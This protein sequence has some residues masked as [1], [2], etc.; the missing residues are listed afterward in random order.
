MILTR[1]VTVTDAAWLRLKATVPCRRIRVKEN[2]EAAGWPTARW[3]AGGGILQNATDPVNPAEPTGTGYISLTAG[4][5]KVF[6]SPLHP[7]AYRPNEHVA[8][9]RLATGG[10]STTFDISEE[11]SVI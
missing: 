5:E 3:R 7:D 8:W 6:D 1:Q 9:V 11:M 10:G 4:Y 2:P